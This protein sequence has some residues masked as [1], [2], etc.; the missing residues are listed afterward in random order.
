MKMAYQPL[1]QAEFE[2]FPTFLAQWRKAPPIL[3]LNTIAQ[4]AALSNRFQLTT[5]IKDSAKKRYPLE[6]IDLSIYI[7]GYFYV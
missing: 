5:S 2:H 1:R 7:S 4:F 3:A 6:N